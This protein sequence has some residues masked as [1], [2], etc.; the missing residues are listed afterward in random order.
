MSSTSTDNSD[1]SLN[2]DETTSNDN[3]TL[4]EISEA[5]KHYLAKGDGKTRSYFYVHWSQ[6]GS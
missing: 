6:K 5:E 2:E 3:Q 4:V 1:D